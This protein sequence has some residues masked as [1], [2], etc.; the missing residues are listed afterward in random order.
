MFEVL[1]LNKPN[2][3]NYDNIQGFLGEQ[4]VEIADME[5]D[6][7]LASVAGYLYG[8]SALCYYLSADARYRSSDVDH[9]WCDRDARGRV[10]HLRKHV[11]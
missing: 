2:L 7:Q 3:K 8:T 6:T 10:P 1:D 9:T 5:P 4:L 11:G